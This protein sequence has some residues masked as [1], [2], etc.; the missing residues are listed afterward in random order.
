MNIQNII[1]ETEKGQIKELIS[2]KIKEVMG[3]S[4]TQFL[5]E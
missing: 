1:G 3:L 4:D 5:E 2:K